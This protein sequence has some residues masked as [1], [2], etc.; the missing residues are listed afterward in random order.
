MLR[1]RALASRIVWVAVVVALLSCSGFDLDKPVAP[2]LRA[3][4]QAA[5]SCVALSGGGIRSGAVSLGVL[6]GLY[7]AHQ[8]SQYQYLS[9]V[10]G[11]GYPV[12]G[13]LDQM[14]RKHRSLGDLLDEKGKFIRDVDTHSHF[15]SKSDIYTAPVFG[16]LLWDP[17]SWLPNAYGGAL[18]TYE[19]KIHSTFTGGHLLPLFGTL[20][21]SSAKDIRELGLPLPIFGASANSGARAP[22]SGHLYTFG[23]FFEMS[24]QG[25]GAPN[26]GYFA[27]VATQMDIA[28]AVATSASA[29]DTPQGNL[30][31]PAFA[32]STNFGLGY[33]FHAP[34]N[35]PDRRSLNLEDGGFIENLGLL[36]LL[37]HGC[38]EILVFDNSADDRP[39]SSWFTIEEHLSTE[40]QGWSVTHSI[41]ASNGGVAPP[42]YPEHGNVPPEIMKIWK[43]HLS[44]HIWDAQVSN[45]DLRTHIRIVKLGLMDEPSRRYPGSVMDFY[46]TAVPD[47]TP[48]CSGEGLHQRCSFPLEATS[49]Q[50]FEMQEFQAYRH[51]GTWLAE[52]ALET[53]APIFR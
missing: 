32:K 14:L 3:T 34:S 4:P 28:Q 13:I 7:A 30:Q 48:S 9:A 2:P 16:V 31:L 50:S 5:V 47:R 33:R 40:E 22:E 19:A 29:I 51:L 8:L 36:P 18:P 53:P 44:D 46:A 11:G 39:F 45:G 52:L 43:W 23:D 20:S 37:R 10:S 6:Q 25:G 21:L 35:G 15:I 49:R 17:L 27:D 42:H 38:S 24:P 26:F 1:Y 12:Y 41:Q